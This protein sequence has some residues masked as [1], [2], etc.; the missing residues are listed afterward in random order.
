M[1][2]SVCWPTSWL[3]KFCDGLPLYRLENMAPRIG[4][5]LLR[6]TMACRMIRCGDLIEPLISK[7]HAAQMAHNIIQMGETT[8]QFLKQNGR[9]PQSRS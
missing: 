2:F 6:A 4:V 3:P 1:L 7:M 9:A 5:I 8:V